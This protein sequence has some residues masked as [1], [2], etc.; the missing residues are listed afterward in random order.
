MY[1][2]EVLSKF[3]VVQHFPFGSLFSWDQD[4]TA[5]APATSVHTSNQPSTNSTGSASSQAPTRRTPQDATSVPWAGQSADLPPSAV[6]TAAP[7]VGK[8]IL[9]P[10]TAAATE[11][12]I[13]PQIPAKAPWSGSDTRSL[14]RGM[15][16]TQAPWATEASSPNAG[17][18]PPPTRA[19]W[20]KPGSGTGGN[21]G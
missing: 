16:T 10:T 15:P 3:P 11:R 9:T 14:V 2:G 1:S 17:S 8:V 12:H 19:P 7:W 6:H 13:P 4:P 20:A 21:G 18:M 5:T